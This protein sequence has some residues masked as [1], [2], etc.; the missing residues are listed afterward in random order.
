MRGPIEMMYEKQQESIRFAQKYILLNR[1]IRCIRSSYPV[2][3][4]HPVAILTKNYK[5]LRFYLTPLAGTNTPNLQ[6]TSKP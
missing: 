2:A 3:I 5:I 4:Q 6:R 1:N